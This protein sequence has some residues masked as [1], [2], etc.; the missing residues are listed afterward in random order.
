MNFTTPQKI[1]DTISA[2]D[3]MR[4]AR[5]NNRA[6]INEA[7]N[8]APPLSAEEAKKS[9]MHVNFN[10]LELAML[11]A[12]ARRQ[13]LTAF[14][15]KSNFF[16]VTLKD[17]PEDKSSAWGRFITNEINE[18]M[19]DSLRYYEANLNVFSS[20]V[21]H[22]P[23]VG[24][25]YD[26]DDWCKSFVAIEDFVVPTDS[27]TDMS[28]WEWFAIWK[29][30]TPGELATKV[31]S[32][33]TIP[34]WKKS[35]VG[36]IL[37][38]YR[39]ENYS[40]DEYDWITQS[41][42]ILEVWKQNMGY[43]TSDAVPTVPCYHFY[44][45]DK[46]NGEN[47]WLMRVVPDPSLRADE[48]KDKFLFNNGNNFIADDLQE[49]LCIQFGDLNNKPPRMFWSQRS[50][51]FLLYE[52]A[53]WS[54]MILCRQVQ[55][56]MQ[57]FNP[58]FRV[59][60]PAGKAR[61][62]KVEMYDKAILPEGVSLVPQD[63][64][65]QID[66][67]ALE[68]VASR[69][70]QLMSEASASYTQQLDTGTQK[71]Q[72]ATETMAKMQ[73][74][75]AMMSGI[76]QNAMQYAKQ[77]YKEVCR[78]FCKPGTTD[79]DAMRFQKH[80]Q[81]YG[82][83]REQLNVRGWKI[84]PVMPLGGGNPTIGLLRSQQLVSMRAMYDPEA[85]QEILHDATVE[86][87]G[88]P[89][90]ADRWVKLGRNGDPSD[91]AVTAGNSFG[92]LMQGVQSPMKRGLNPQDQIK[93]LLAQVGMM[94]QNAEKSGNMMAQDK[95]TGC[96]NV[97]Q[98]IGKLVAL[99]NED[100]AQAGYVQKIKV[101]EGKIMN[102]LKGFA[103]R[104]AAAAKAAQARPDPEAAAK[105]AAIQQQSQLKLQTTAAS[106]K[107]KLA[108]KDATFKADQK[109]KNAALIGEQTRKTIAEAA[110]QHRANA[111]VIGDERRKNATAN[112]ELQRKRKLNS[113]DDE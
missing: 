9:K 96:V 58:W 88:D 104:N 76:L 12:E 60:D 100:K 66:K 102:A 3:E 2:S 85:Q 54:N 41:E 23:G 40:T 17:A 42:K 8:G 26:D 105:A 95:V 99:L 63:E 70:R 44:F 33:D 97:M 56:V 72:T 35:V 34:G 83:P 84:A 103:Q 73:K 107:Q 92:T 25:W 15:G 94:I 69:M 37:N 68:G 75:T 71:E 80:C 51:G 32:K 39:D 4:Q 18:V 31:F 52:P 6:K 64:R 43:W 78:R 53:F 19:M 61:A 36:K 98:H 86:I 55:Y 93:V 79:P 67:D 13:F 20:V 57:N 77:E 10:T 45:R 106:T 87:T 49:L 30:Y 74:L 50:L 11:F 101:I 28:R 47:G 27:E 48:G 91:A 82:I 14:Y 109:R 21:A 90:R 22:G 62:Q 65:H 81:E 5:A 89:R 29:A 38:Q 1:L 59:I 16:D 7:A 46:V 108:I 113:L 24:I 110:T 111:S 112:G